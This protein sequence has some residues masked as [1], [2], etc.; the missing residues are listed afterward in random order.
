MRSPS[1]RR[2]VKKSAP[3]SILDIGTLGRLEL[4]VGDTEVSLAGRKNHSLIGYL[5][6]SEHAQETRERL[7][8]LLWSEF[9]EEKAR[10]S[11]RQGLHEIR[12]A[13][14][15]A[16]FDGLIADKHTI[17][18]DPS[19]INVDLWRI[20]RE[21]EQ[22]RVSPLLQNGRPHL[23]NIL[24]QNETVDPAFRGWLLAKRQTL[25]DRIV[26][27][28]EGALRVAQQIGAQEE[29]A[30]AIINLDP[31][32]E[33]AVRAHM[34]ARVDA[35]DIG[36]ALSAYKALWDI[37]A[38]EYDIEPSKET[39]DYIAEL[40]QSQPPVGN[41]SQ[42]AIAQTTGTSTGE[43]GVSI[44][45]VVE[46]AKPTRDPRLILAIGKFDGAGISGDSQYLVHGFRRELIA[47]LVRFREW[48]V[49]EADAAMDG[50]TDRAHAGEY[51]IEAY[52]VPVSAEVRLILTLRDVVTNV[53]LWGER[54][55]ISVAS[56]SDTQQS[57]I[58]NI[59]AALNVHVSAGRLA[60]ISRSLGADV[61]TYDRWL[62]GQ[63][64]ILSFSPTDW[65][66]AAELFREI[67]ADTPSFSPAHSSLAQLNNIIHLAHHGVFR[68]AA[69]AQEALVHARK[70]TML[71]P[72]DSRSHLALGWA[73]LMANQ[74]ELA[75]THYL[76]AGDLND[77]DPW[78]LVSSGLAFAFSGEG[79]R[80]RDLADRALR[81]A[82]NPGPTHWGYQM[83]IRFLSGD[84]E[85]AYDAAHYA[86]DVPAFP[87][88]KAAL[89]YSLGQHSAAAAEL[90]RF[91]RVAQQRW[92]GEGIWSP[93]AVM[94]WFLHSF[95][96]KR[97]DDWERL[98]DCLVA[99]GAPSTD[100]RYEICDIK[101]IDRP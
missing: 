55:T 59:A 6:L 58:R 60:S 14:E 66:H 82:V 75:A 47:C 73:Y 100:L 86:A 3:V 65:H 63:S 56:W 57:I 81:L 27:S 11:L 30:R 94:R 15:I 78:T 68:T 93:E 7:I 54:V 31:T 5:A 10:A 38:D 87:G 71:D 80:A 69:R 40:R 76:I 33:A 26:R 19:R 46:Y 61:L 49:R 43:V 36:G 70:A 85:G 79:D 1:S 72:I 32:H 9:D 24:E 89:L 25:H 22:G 28:L 62:R 51:V 21:A 99:T 52:T 67:I 91:F 17:A 45:Q 41:A 29:I 53:Y 18:L 20:L 37:L 98:R 42:T 13:L 50:Q 12:R 35:G 96:F 101:N 34:R 83:R 84:L 2:S 48:L 90:H 97:C 39:Q 74:H 4:R 23:E 88:W 92:G 77:N 8:G 44:T 64:Q 95:P 16:G